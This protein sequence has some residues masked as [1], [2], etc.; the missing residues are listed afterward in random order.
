VINYKY[1]TKCGRYFTR[2]NTEFISYE[3]L[4]PYRE[5]K[6]VLRAFVAKEARLWRC[7]NGDAVAARFKVWEAQTRDCDACQ[8]EMSV[9]D[10]SVEFISFVGNVF[11]TRCNACH[12]SNRRPCISRRPS[13][14]DE[15]FMASMQLQGME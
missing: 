6:E 3:F 8:S 4:Q 10:M 1:R 11:T 12:K 14:E 13:D 7:L 5:G 15:L 9:Y 2:T